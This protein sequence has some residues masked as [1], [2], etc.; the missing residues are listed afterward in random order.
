MKKILIVAMA[1]SVHTARWLRQFDDD[2]IE[3]VLFVHLGRL[4][5]KLT[6]LLADSKGV[7]S[8]DLPKIL[9]SSLL[10]EAKRFLF[11]EFISKYLNLI[12]EWS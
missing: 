1:D 9:L 10:R 2:E 3:F 8:T 6:K 5:I 11:L 4:K 7:A 12:R